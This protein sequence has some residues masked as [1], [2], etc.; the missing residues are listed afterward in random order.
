[1]FPP[2]LGNR[3][4]VGLATIRVAFV[5]VPQSTTAGGQVM[6]HLPKIGRR[7]KHVPVDKLASRDTRDAK[8]FGEPAPLLEA[9]RS[10]PF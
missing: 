7:Y 1:M 6:N 8:P 3:D 4:L 10:E 9:P 5:F 2:R